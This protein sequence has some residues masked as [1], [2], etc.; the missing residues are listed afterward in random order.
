MIVEF[1]RN[2]DSTP[3]AVILVRH[4]GEDPASAALTIAGFVASVKDATK[5]ALVDTGD[6]VS[7]FVLWEADIGGSSISS[8]HLGTSFCAPASEYLYQLVRLRTI[9]GAVHVEIVMDE[10]TTE[11]ELE[12]ASAILTA[13]SIRTTFVAATQSV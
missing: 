1:Y 3:M 11:Q 12:D 7:R 9:D 10:Y 5:S 6:L 4:C 8:P 2:N 13:A